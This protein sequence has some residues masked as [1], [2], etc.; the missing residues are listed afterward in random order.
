[1]KCLGLHNKPKAEVH[2]GYKLTGPKE[3]EEEEELFYLQR[4]LFDCYMCEQFRQRGGGRRYKL[5]GPSIPGGGPGPENVVCLAHLYR[6]YIL[7]ISD[8]A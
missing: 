2:P 5:L 3:E 6:L 4:N 8:Q 7:T 1:M